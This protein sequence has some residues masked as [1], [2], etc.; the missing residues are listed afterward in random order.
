MKRDWFYVQQEKLKLEIT[1]IFVHVKRYSGQWWKKSSNNTMKKYFITSEGPV[2]T[3][4]DSISE[5]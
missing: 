3:L 5:V 1:N 2:S 4:N